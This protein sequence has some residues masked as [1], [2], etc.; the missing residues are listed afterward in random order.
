MRWSSRT[1]TGEDGEF[2]FDD[3]QPGAYSIVEQ[4]LDVVGLPQ[5][6]A[7][8]LRQTWG[9]T[10]PGTPIRTGRNDVGSS[11][12]RRVSA[13]G[14]AFR[15]AR[16]SGQGLGR[17][18]AESAARGDS[19]APASS[20]GLHRFDRREGV[21]PHR[22]T[23]R[24]GRDRMGM[25]PGQRSRG[26]RDASAHGPTVRRADRAHRGPRAD[27]CPARAQADA[28]HMRGNGRFADA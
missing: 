11:P 18:R 25:R 23:S 26:A 4:D 19:R 16:G 17:D 2:A 12:R 27:R 8:P 21:V 10:E 15:R 6:G 3:L 5:R 9:A 14:R 20:D 7:G 28:V 1:R 13:R 22:A 24:G